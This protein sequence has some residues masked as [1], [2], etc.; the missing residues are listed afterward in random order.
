MRKLLSIIL[1]CMPLLGMAQSEWERPMTAAEKLEQA[2]KA[3]EEAKKAIKEAKKAAKAERKKQKE[4]AKLAA[5]Q[6]P[7]ATQQPNDEPQSQGWQAP[8]PKK[9]EAKQ[10]KK[11]EAKAM[12]TKPEAQPQPKD[13]ED[14][15]YL[16]PNAVPEKDGEVVYTLNLDLPGLNAQQIYERIYDYLDKLSQEKNQIRS[17]IAIFNKKDHTVAAKYKEW[18]EFNRSFFS[19][20]RTEF[21]YTVIATCTDGHMDMTLERMSYNYDEGRDSGFKETAEKII[22][23]KYAVN[24]KRTKLLPGT[25]K[26]R[27]ATINRKNEIFN[28]VKA[29]FK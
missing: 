12:P 26:F 11:Q 5:K 1:A 2:Q 7:K 25:G 6:A 29:L 13:P 4:E 17:G 22:T 8:E 14:M 18:L 10:P 24:K 3:Q 28:A 20:D 27:K 19:L 15:P 21:N 23:D 16:E 9:Q